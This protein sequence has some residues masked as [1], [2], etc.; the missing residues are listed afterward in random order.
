MLESDDS[1]EMQL[2]DL[3]SFEQ[4]VCELLYVIHN[5]KNPSEEQDKA[6]ISQY[7][8]PLSRDVVFMSKSLYF[9]INEEELDKQPPAKKIEEEE[10]KVSEQVLQEEFEKL[11]VSPDEIAYNEIELKIDERLI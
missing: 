7:C 3:E 9:I 6:K 2:K 5:R 10:K 4:M 8:L 11:E 1:H